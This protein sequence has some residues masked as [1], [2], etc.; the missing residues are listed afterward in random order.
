MTPP[1]PPEPPESPERPRSPVLPDSAACV[2]RLGP[3]VGRWRPAVLG[4]AAVAL[5]FLLIVAGWM[6]RAVS[7]GPVTGALAQ[8]LDQ[9]KQ[10]TIQYPRDVQ[11]RQEARQVDA[12][13]RDFELGRRI[14]LAQGAWLLV[15]AATIFVLCLKLAFY[16]P[17]ALPPAVLQLPLPADDHTTRLVERQHRQAAWGVLGVAALLLGFVSPWFNVQVLW[18]PWSPSAGQKPSLAAA[19]PSPPL[20]ELRRNWPR[21]RGADGQ[22]IVPFAQVPLDWDG[23]SGRGVLWKTQVPLPGHSS[24]VIWGDHL[25]I[26]AADKT[27]KMVYCYH[28][29]TGRLMWQRQVILPQP[30]PAEDAYE[31]T[32]YAASTMATDGRYACAIFTHGET[33]C[34]DM[35]GRQLWARRLSVTSNSY[36]HAAS[37]VIWQNEL[38]L[39]LD[40]GDASDGLSAILALDLATGRQLWRTARPVASSW[41]TPIIIG[42]A[43]QQLLITT[44]DPFVIAYDPAT[45]TEIWR[46]KCLDA[47]VVPS[48]IFN[49]T[50]G[51]Q[52]IALNPSNAIVALK[53]LGQGDVTATAILW[54]GGDN[55]PDISSPVAQDGYIYTAN[56]GGTVVCTRAADGKTI[57]TH[58]LEAPVLASPSISSGRLLVLAQDGV[59]HVLKTGPQFAE[60]THLTVGEPCEATPAFLPGR[61]FIRAQKH[62]F[63]FAG[64]RDTPGKGQGTS[65]QVSAPLSLRERVGVRVNPPNIPTAAMLP[66]PDQESKF[67]DQ[68]S[69]CLLS[70]APNP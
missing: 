40:R 59:L 68:E 69:P 64:T 52:I 14:L 41:S 42:L 62:L 21:F 50:N 32:G 2:P 36:G 66:L 5:V 55:V 23:P 39:Q 65:R 7:F 10:E 13:I 31:D 35:T 37:L 46:A 47:E 38:I 58:D 56:S 28:A 54:Q 61:L 45:G 17:H 20:A 9:L 18:H 3:H 30:R 26:T 22:G 43:G 4:V 33:A 12:R 11:T 63:C 48:P 6:W 67:I 34:F 15:A 25:F 8:P 27:H 1:E 44:A 60:L 24:P 57:W 70:L 16:R 19:P 53:P 29:A 49:S 51:G